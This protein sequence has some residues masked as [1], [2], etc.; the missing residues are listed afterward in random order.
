MQLNSPFCRSYWMKGLRRTVAKIAIEGSVP[1]PRPL[2]LGLITADQRPLT[3]DRCAPFYRPIGGCEF[4]ADGQPNAE[5]L[6]DRSKAVPGAV[7]VTHVQQKPGVRTNETGF[8]R[9]VR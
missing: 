5:E 8:S 7:T 9:S 1:G 6:L 2:K 4:G 3:T